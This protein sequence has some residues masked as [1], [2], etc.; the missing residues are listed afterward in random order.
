MGFLDDLAD[1]LHPPG[2]DQREA[3]A[4]AAK[5]G[6]EREKKAKV[7]TSDM[8]PQ[9]KPKGVQ[10][11]NY[12]KGGPVFSKI[13]SDEHKTVLKHKDGHEVH[14]AHRSLDEKMKKQ[15]DALP[16]YD[17]GGDVSEQPQ[18]F[19]NIPMNEPLPEELP[20]QATPAPTALPENVQITSPT[21]QAASPIPQIDMAAP[22]LKA[23]GEQ[24]RGIRHEAAAIGEQGKKEALQSGMQAQ[25]LEALATDYRDKVSGLEKERQDFMQDIKNNHI[26]PNRFVK[27][28][29]TSGQ[30]ATAIGLMLGGMGSGLTGQANPALKVLQDNI[31]RDVQAQVNDQKKQEGLLHATMQQ[32]GNQHDATAMTRVL[33]TDM[34]ADKIAR[35][36]AES[37]SPIAQAQAEKAIGQLH[38]QTA[39]MLQQIAQTQ[40]VNDLLKRGEM[41]PEQAV[42]FK[43][44][45]SHQ[46]AVFKEIERAQ[47]TQHM[48]NNIME[49]FDKAA[50]DARPLS[51]GSV[52]NLI[53]GQTSPYVKALHQHMQPTFQDL[54]GTVRQA[55][56]DNTFENITPKM[57][58]SDKIIAVKRQAL[59]Q[60]LKAK[61]SAPTAK[62]FGIDLG[63]FSS[64]RPTDKPAPNPRASYNRRQAMP[65]LINR[66]TGAAEDLGHD[67]AQQALQSTHDVPLNDPE[68]N[69]VI[70]SYDQ[71]AN[72][73]QQGYT[74]PKPEQ[75]QNLLDFSKSEQPAEMAKTFAEGAGSGATFGLSTLAERAMGV[76]PEDINR[77]R[78]MN[79]KMHI[80]GELAGLA[81]STA[82]TGPATGLME[83]AG[84]GAGKIAAKILGAGAIGRIGSTAAKMAAENAIFQ[85]GSEAS[86]LFASDPN[87][88][89]ETAVANIGLS[90]L[91]GMGAGAAFKGTGELW[92]L[93]PGK[94]LNEMLTAISNKAEGL[95]SE[96]KLASGI[97]IAPEMEAALSTNPAAQSAFQ[98]LQESTTKAGTKAQESFAKF[99]DDIKTATAT[100]L[101]KTPE[102]IQ[103]LGSMS[104]AETGKAL[105][106]SL[107]KT[108]EDRVGPISEQYNKFNETFANAEFGPAAKVELEN[109]IAKLITEQG[110]AKGANEEG[111]KLAQKA[112]EQVKL[113]ENAKDLKQYMQSLYQS[114]PYGSEKYQTGKELRKLFNTSLE[115]TISSAAASRGEN[116]VSE[117][118]ALKQ[119]YAQFKDVLSDLNDRLHL[120]REGKAGAESF[121]NALK[122]SD[123]ETIASRL[124]LKGDTNLQALLAQQFP[125]VAQLARTSEINKIIRSSLDKSGDALDPKKL[126]K[127]L[128]SV[129]PELRN[130]ML[131]P[132][133]NAQL[134]ALE[135]L[136]DRVPQRMNPSGTAKTL[137]ALW[138]RMPEGAAAA[139][140]MLTGHNPISGYL[141][142]KAANYVGKEVPDAVRLA[143]LKYLGGSGNISAEGFKAAVSTASAVLKGEKKLTQAVESV[144]SGGA[145]VIQFPTPAHLE[146]LSKQIDKIAMDP[147]E[148]LDNDN[149]M[150]HYVQDHAAA[151]G[152]INGR[153]VS[154]LASLR[155]ATAPGAPLDAKPIPSST[156]EAAYRNALLIAEQ[157]LSV[158]QSIKEG[159]LTTQD[160]VHLHTMYP[161]LYQRMQDKLVSQMTA[162]MGKDKAIPYKTKLSLSMFMAQ[163]LESSMQPQ[164]IMS[165]QLSTMPPPMQAIP[166]Q[167]TRS[168]PSL[169]K[170]PQSYQTSQQN[171][172]ADKQRH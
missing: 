90:G 122:A 32:F 4:D 62:G 57:G 114:A 125:E 149:Q 43:V 75:L 128:N 140:A 138:K 56:M 9:Y 79:P 93:G 36:A 34:Y 17:M 166:Q 27:N 28:L 54:E 137:D 126:F 139:V 38:A 64:T 10:Y 150:G 58:D 161:A 120:G 14:V 95:P 163:P 148:L 61:S 169:T 92:K 42:R 39:P 143:Y 113:Q 30:V 94:Q 123:P 11:T 132:E 86:K 115:D 131:S 68:G 124:S 165:A 109:N 152:E 60:Y 99:N 40:M 2:T 41:V 136:V 15:L 12:A 24:E 69:P 19:S 158:I 66:E 141:L 167:R 112:L 135:E 170:L 121:I 3:A 146:K 81:G 154:Y 118:G 31:D 44:P 119:Q 29:S 111:L 162:S 47:N 117:Y 25:R 85:G 7:K 129:E 157:P 77:R 22:I 142:G 108:L 116:V 87:Q 160:I 50:V 74:Q 13:H 6:E 103:M 5:K 35:I 80:A 104:K 88:S 67:I 164:A 107:A 26:D 82:L 110:L 96:L 159:T 59:S 155:P 63:D 45:E 20:E 46:A 84:A 98:T 53:P 71:A 102:D 105:Q 127:N 52:R 78:E 51:G 101:N 144:F 18:D 76:K 55:A 33:I 49:A 72:L 83:I 134:K 147:Q 73:L 89:M 171:R 145:K 8:F 37:K 23:Q 70:A 168:N 153:A 65:V 172:E 100:A 16:H 133:A 97:D 21:P 130:Y 91:L 1:K 48:G 106:D 156:A 151:T